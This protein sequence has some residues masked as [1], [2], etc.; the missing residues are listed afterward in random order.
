MKDNALKLYEHY[1]KIG[2]T[3]ALENMREH[4]KRKYK[5]DPDS[6]QEEKKDGKKSKG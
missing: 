4:I 6:K 1:K 2:Y 5:I 3:S